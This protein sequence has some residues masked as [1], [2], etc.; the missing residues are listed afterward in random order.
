MNM[1]VFGMSLFDIHS[2]LGLSPV[3]YPCLYHVIYCHEYCIT[4]SILVSRISDIPCFTEVRTRFWTFGF[5][6]VYRD[7]LI[8]RFYAVTRLCT[9][10]CISYM[11]RV[12]RP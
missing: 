8:L 7:Y 12:P 2:M 10:I 3:T 9:S 4:I 6:H 5:S 11:I 1:F